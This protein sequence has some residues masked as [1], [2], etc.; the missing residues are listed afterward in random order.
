MVHVLKM[1][2]HMTSNLLV[3]HFIKKIEK[4]AY[5]GILQ[6]VYPASVMFGQYSRRVKALK[7]LAHST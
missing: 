2:D 7:A 6:Y 4:I 5:H 3:C 1:D